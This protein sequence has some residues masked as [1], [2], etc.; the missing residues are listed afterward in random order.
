MG[1][2]RSRSKTSSKEPETTALVD[3]FLAHARFERGLSPNTVDAYRRDLV[4][5]RGFC[6]LRSI[7]LTAVRTRDVTEYLERLRSGKPLAAQSYHPS[8][9]ARMLTSVRSL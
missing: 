3:E 2:K 8:S 6:A 5:W 7:D 9:V 1:S 4:V